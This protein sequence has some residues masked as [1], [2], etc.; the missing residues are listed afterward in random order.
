MPER[1]DG[2]EVGAGAAPRVLGV[3]EDLH[4]TADPPTAPAHARGFDELSVLEQSQV[5]E[6]IEDGRAVT[7][8]AL[9]S[10]AYERARAMQRGFERTLVWGAGVVVVASLGVWLFGDDSHRVVGAALGIITVPLGGAWLLHARATAIR[11]AE[12]N[13]ALLG[14]GEGARPPGIGA[15]VAAAILGLWIGSMTARWAGVGVLAVAGLGD[16]DLDA[17]PWYWSAPLVII[18]LG[19]AYAVY[20]AFTDPPRR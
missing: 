13:A 2:R 8:P 11:A 7:H 17:L 4:E 18:W 5:G 6:A 16:R 12:E 20:R 1:P 9:A 19:V 15:R 10:A 3:D 14:E